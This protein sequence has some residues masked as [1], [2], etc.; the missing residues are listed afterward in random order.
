[1]SYPTDLGDLQYRIHKASI[2]KGWWGPQED[3][4]RYKAA[5]DVPTVM[6]KL[7]LVVTEVAEAAEAVRDD[8]EKSWGDRK[9]YTVPDK[10]GHSKPEGLGPELADVVIRVMDLAEACGIGLEQE[11]INK[12]LYNETREHRHGGRHA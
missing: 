1:M 10:R 11:I 4:I 3:D 8:G 12:V 7:M 5:L 6:M 2:E 9:S